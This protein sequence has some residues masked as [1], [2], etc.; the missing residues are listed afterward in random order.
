MKLKKRI[1]QNNLIGDNSLLPLV[2]IIFLLLIFFLLAGVIEKKRDLF[3]VKLPEATLEQ[4]SEKDTP[5]MHVYPNGKIRVA[6][7]SVTIKNLSKSLKNEFPKLKE[8]ELLVTADAYVTAKDLNQ[9]LLILNKIQVKKISL[10][11]LKN[12]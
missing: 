8:S 9:I 6:G 2:N 5:E 12:E 4:F 11:T 1:S 7:N 3:N 10:L